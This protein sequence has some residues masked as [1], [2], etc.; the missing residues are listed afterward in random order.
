VHPAEG[1]FG[2]APFERVR[3]GLNRLQ[4]DFFTA[5]AQWGNVIGSFFFGLIVYVSSFF[6][7]DVIGIIICVTLLL[8]NEDD[9]HEEQREK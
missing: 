1:G 5:V 7:R 3:I 4:W 2:T 8:P 9:T 6:V